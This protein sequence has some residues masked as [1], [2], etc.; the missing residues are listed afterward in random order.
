MSEGGLSRILPNNAGLSEA[1]PQ[2]GRWQHGEKQTEALCQV[3][4]HRGQDESTPQ[5]KDGLKPRKLGSNPDCPSPAIWP[6]SQDLSFL[7]SKTG[8]IGALCPP[9]GV[10]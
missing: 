4:R 9:R 6:V 3:P 2:A 7:T 10:G 1:T 5:R 8:Q